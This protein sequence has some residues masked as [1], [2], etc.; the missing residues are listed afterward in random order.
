MRARRLL[1]WARALPALVVWAAGCEV[2]VD[3]KLGE[4]RCSQEGAIGPPACPAGLLC[5]DAL[6][7]PTVLGT[8]CLHDADCAAGDFC[9]EPA[10]VGGQGTKRC[11]RACCQSGDCDPDALFVCWSAPRGAGSVC[12]SALEVGRVEGGARRALTTCVS[13]VDCRSGLCE[14]GRCADTCCS[15]TACAAGGG[16][17]S[18]G[19]APNGEVPG[20]WC[21]A[22]P[23]D[24]KPRYAI[25]ATDAECATG[26][27]V[28]FS[29]GNDKRCSTP[30]CASSECELAPGKGTP[31]A[32]APVLA[33]ATWMRACSLLVLGQADREV[34]SACAADGDCRSGFCADQDGKMRCSDACCS[35]A[36]CGDPSSF[37]C[38]PVSQRASWALRC[39][40]K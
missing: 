38:R 3:G 34:G 33:G 32:C 30:C 21:S 27:C 12:R 14:H 9:L 26:L 13:D 23:V 29:P 8:P 24:K 15:D 37:V 10:D 28:R 40:P 18:F 19:P 4:V 11:S 6:C 39:E 1:A 5:K 17:C 7:V 25:C 31:I 2:L 16:A 22:P 35:D 36:S 20:F